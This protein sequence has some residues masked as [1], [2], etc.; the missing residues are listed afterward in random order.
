MGPTE[1]IAVVVPVSENAESTLQCLIG[2]DI[3]VKPGQSATVVITAETRKDVL[4]YH[5]QSLRADKVREW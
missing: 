1:A 3:D 4:F 2:K 5:F